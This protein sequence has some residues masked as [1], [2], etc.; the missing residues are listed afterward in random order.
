MSVYNSIIIIVNI[1]LTIILTFVAIWFFNEY[2]INKL[3]KRINNFS[4]AKNDVRHS[5]FDSFV[6]I[7]LSV[8][9]FIK[10]IL[11]KSNYFCKYS[12]R[13][14]KYVNKDNL[15]LLDKM[16]FVATKFF[17]SFFLVF[18]LFLS[19]AFQIEIF[20]ISNIIIAFS[21][22]YFLL[23]FFLAGS[24]KYLLYE[25]KN[26]L[27]KAITIMNNCF[28]SGKS[29]IQTIEIVKDEID[30]PLKKEFQKMHDDLSFGLELEVVFERFNKRVNLPEVK[31]ITTSLNILNMTGG[32]VI[33]VFD[34][35]EKT[36][37]TNKKLEEELRNL[38]AAS[39]A[40]YRLLMII[41]VIFVLLIFILDSTY[42]M[43]LFTSPLGL[44]IVFL[45]LLIYVMYIIVIKKIVKV[46]EI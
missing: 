19:S 31:Y 17:L 9:S 7:F 41:P 26:D 3:N 11:L 4:I 6:N 13:Y 35:I 15:M 39:K 12:E 33:V 46:K 44:L 5:L 43:P 25:M 1:L 2:R 42:F 16:D 34:L 45:I 23:D 37:F 24:R 14:E 30:G 21:L 32:N 27:L 10:K 29:I 8:R 40:L 22:G 18:I 36:V 38:S 20:N 28:K